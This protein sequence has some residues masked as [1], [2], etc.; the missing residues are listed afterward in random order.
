MNTTKEMHL[1]KEPHVHHARK[2]SRTRNFFRKAKFGI[3]GVAAALALYTFAPKT[4]NAEDASLTIYP[5]YSYGIQNGSH[6]MNLRVSGGGRLPYGI[7]ATGIVNALAAEADSPE[8][9]FGH[10]EFRLHRLFG[11]LGPLVQYEIEPGED[12]LRAGLVFIPF[13]SQDI[14]L[15]LR[16]LSFSVGTQNH[17]EATDFLNTKL[18]LYFWMNITDDLR[19]ETYWDWVLNRKSVSGEAALDYMFTS[20]LG[21]GAQVRHNFSFDGPDSTSVLLRGVLRI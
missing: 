5:A 14:N 2:G 6:G 11:W 12:S 21:L 4:A 17:G 9:K 13:I 19:V 20:W 10:T 15:V 1:N 3:Y 16:V 18:A 8:L 7:A